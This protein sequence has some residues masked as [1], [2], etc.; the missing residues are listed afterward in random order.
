MDESRTVE[1]K[2]SMP[3]DLTL[4]DVTKAYRDIARHPSLASGKISVTPKGDT[5]SIYSIR[6][7]WSQ[8]DIDRKEKTY[9][10]KTFSLQLTKEAGKDK[11][12][13]IGC[14]IPQEMK[15]VLWDVESPS[16]KKRAVVLKTKDKKGEDKQFVEIWN[17]KQKEKTIDVKALDKHGDIVGNDGQFGSLQWSRCENYLLYIAERKK[18]KTASFFEAISPKDKGDNADM[19]VKGGEYIYQETWGEQLV[20]RH[21]TVVCQPNVSTDQVTLLDQVPDQYSPGQVL[22]GPDNEVVFAA[23]CHEPFRLGLRFCVQRRSSVFKASFDGGDCERLSEEGR[24][25]R[26]LSFSPDLSRLVYLDTADGGPH[27]QCSRLVMIDWKKWVGSENKEAAREIIIDTVNRPGE[28]G[29]PGLY[30]WADQGGQDN[31]LSDNVHVLFTSFWRSRSAVVVI[32]TDT[33]RVHSLCPGHGD[34]ACSLLDVRG[35]DVLIGCS[36]PDLPPFPVLA[37]LDP[38]QP[39]QAQWIVLEG[40]EASPPSLTQFEHKLLVLD[41]R[42]M[43]AAHK[44]YDYLDFEAIL[45]LPVKGGDDK[46]K[47][48]LVV[49]PHGGPHSC[50]DRGF[51]LNPAVFAC[52]GFAV[53]SVNY[54]GSLGFGQDSINSLLGNVGNFDVKDCILAMQ[55]VQEM[56]VVD[57]QN[58]FVYG[59][60]HGGFLSAH[61]I[62]QYPDQFRAASMRN[63]VT[64]LT[65]M[66]APTDIPDWVFTE[67]G[68][69][70]EYS[71]LAKD[72]YL[73]TL[74]NA[75]PVSHVDSV[76]TPVMLH[77]GLKDLRVPPSQGLEYYKMLKA[78]NVPVQCHTYPDSN[79]SLAEV[80]VE[81]DS[82]VHSILWFVKHL[83]HQ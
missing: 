62:G 75:S 67:A 45:Y 34:L 25:A 6:T 37:Q 73:A 16:G 76:K 81:A 13:Y 21:R 3:K 83:P 36:W 60:S 82:L 33:K 52:C 66:A 10:T 8:R 48:P 53:L 24:A 23:W 57:T 59:G 77:I 41:P 51:A 78:R 28:E 80:E 17:Y 38:K 5:Q 35:M 46:T 40:G 14:S 42:N 39:D 27:N 12:S 22:W 49:F 68:L 26:C 74:W 7:G 44:D 2:A 19:T 11:L 69:K 32:N 9:F 61:L 4:D 64:N 79:H 70:F 54:R 47:P 72:D 18:P 56:G 20:E 58:T 29:F 30:T 65:A 50:F 1:G 55:R 63:P 15:N 71:S 43:Q 31:W